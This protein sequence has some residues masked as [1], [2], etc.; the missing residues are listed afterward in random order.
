L[1]DVN[2]SNGSPLNN[3]QES[4]DDRP[5]SNIH[6]D[7]SITPTSLPHDDNNIINNGKQSTN[8]TLPVQTHSEIKVTPPNPDPPQRKR[9]KNIPSSKI[10]RPPVPSSSILT[11]NIK[12]E[13]NIPSLPS[14]PVN[15]S[16][17][18][19]KINAT[20]IFN[21]I[22]LLLEEKKSDNNDENLLSTID[23]LIDS[24]QHLRERIKAIENNNNEKNSLAIDDSYPL[25]LSKPKKR[26]QTRLASTNSDDMSPST[27]TVS[28]PTPSTPTLP[29]PSALFSS[30]ALFY[31]KP[32]FPSFSGRLFLSKKKYSFIFLK[33]SIST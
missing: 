10:S 28:S 23:C 17:T 21:S 7:E 4:N 8:I 1:T 22:R 20:M 6:N 9:R 2:T 27:S 11:N 5:E 32:F 31:E 33:Y 13:K 26:Q 12:L 18:T 24:L 25:N 15:T 29:L 3:N 30:Q 16:P 14:T 19:T